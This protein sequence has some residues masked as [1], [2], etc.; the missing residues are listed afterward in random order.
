MSNE[1]EKKI[2]VRCPRCFS[3]MIY[4]RARKQEFLCR[5]CGNTFKVPAVFPEG[6]S[7]EVRG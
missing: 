7:K 1:F 2:D 4:Y 3:K 6:K 5:F